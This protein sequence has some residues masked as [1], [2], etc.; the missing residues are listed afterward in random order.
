MLAHMTLSAVALRDL[1]N[2]PAVAAEL[3]AVPNRPLGTPDW[4]RLRRVRNFLPFKAMPESTRT[5]DSDV[6]GLL[7]ATRLTGLCF[8]CAILGFLGLFRANS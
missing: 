5:L 4:I 1:A 7:W 8:A 3:F 2:H 6:R